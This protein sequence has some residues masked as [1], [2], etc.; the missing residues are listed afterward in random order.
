[1]PFPAHRRMSEQDDIRLL[2]IDEGAGG[3]KIRFCLIILIS[4]IV[5]HNDHVDARERQRVYGL[6]DGM[7][8]YQHD[9]AI[10]NFRHLRDST[11]RFPCHLS[12]VIAAH[13]RDN[14]ICASHADSLLSFV[15]FHG[16]FIG[17]LFS[18][19]VEVAIHH[20]ART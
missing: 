5:R 9:D 7:P 17:L 16:D 15:P 11:K 20:M 8:Y 2:L 6:P 12:H 19:S 1:M 3:G 13:F 10:L 18:Y 4:I 14:G